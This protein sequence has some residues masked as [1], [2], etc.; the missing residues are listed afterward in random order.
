MQGFDLF[1]SVRITTPAS[2]V[3]CQ[4]SLLDKCHIHLPMPHTAIIFRSYTVSSYHVLY[5]G[6][7]V[8]RHENSTAGHFL[9]PHFLLFGSLCYTRCVKTTRSRPTTYCRVWSL[10]WNV[11]AFRNVI[12][13][14]RLRVTTI[15]V[16]C[17]TLLLCAATSSSQ[18]IARAR[19]TG[20]LCH[21]LALCPA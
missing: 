20:R 15:S 17:T 3:E 19:G 16:P 12:F 13:C 1:G 7:A 18:T 11:A 5:I 6:P 10:R 2:L 21:G 9:W 14:S 4:N 8:R